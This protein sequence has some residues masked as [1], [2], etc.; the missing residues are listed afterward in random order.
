MFVV[1]VRLNEILH[2]RCY[3]RCF[4][5]DDR[6]TFA[7][8]HVENSKERRVRTPLRSLHQPRVHPLSLP[9]PDLYRFTANF[10]VRFYASARL[11]ANIEKAC[12]PQQCYRSPTG[13]RPGNINIGP[14]KEPTD[15]R[16][17]LPAFY[18]WCPRVRNPFRGRLQFRVFFARSL[19]TASIGERS[20][21]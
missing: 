16:G 4:S 20:T 2:L 15:G 8:V 3:I 14:S 17:I 19:R 7:L 21:W 10:Y 13:P 1:S 12:R 18:G 6:P 11:R 9:R 5:C